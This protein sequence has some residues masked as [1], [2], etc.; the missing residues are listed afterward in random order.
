[1]QPI[2]T[3]SVLPVICNEAVDDSDNEDEKK[4]GCLCDCGCVVV[5]M[6]LRRRVAVCV[7]L[8]NKVG[9]SITLWTNSDW[10]GVT[11]KFTL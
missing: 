9:D 5:W 3:S 6:K 8:A 4:S 11:R 10:H 1:M 7:V 2:A